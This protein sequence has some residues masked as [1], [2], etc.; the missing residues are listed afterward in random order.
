MNPHDLAAEHL[1]TY[2]P[3]GAGL[4]FRPERI[5]LT[6]GAL[7]TPP[8]RRFVEAICGALPGA[9]VVEA[10]NRNHMQLGGFLP[11]GD[12]ARREVGRRTLV[13][14]TIAS[15]LRRSNEKGIVCPNYLHFS[16]TGYCPYRCGYCYLAGSCSTVVAPV[17]KVFVNLE[18]VLEAIARRARELTRPTSFYLGKLQDALALDPLTGFS[19][20]LVR[21]FAEQPRARLVMLTKSDRVGNLL[22]VE[23]A[24]KTAVAWSVNPDEVCREFEAG[25][26]SLANRLAAARACQQAG[27][28]VR[29]VIMPVLPVE[30]WRGAYSRL[31][32]RLSDGISPARI[33]MGGI[34][35]Y[36]GALRLTR[37]ALGPD[38]LIS[39]LVER[40]PSPDGRLRFPRNLRVELYRHILAEV[41]T[42]RPGTP[43]GLCLE[44][45]RVWRAVGLDP[46]RPTCNCQW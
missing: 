16:T 26:P 30:G 28:Q 24:G 12:A 35:S 17:V 41:R 21:F 38:N 7:A 45:A 19:R 1:S 11:R 42:R 39:Q 22:E 31:V 25:A 20:V 46:K 8:R 4:G 14:G 40:A 3:R 43:V 33:T 5:I 37:R 23:S 10:T 2:Q 32:E 34:C 13:I 6:R 18:D 9:E 27:Y 15:P 29:F 36:P 44:E